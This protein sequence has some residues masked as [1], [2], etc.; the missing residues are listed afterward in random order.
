[1]PAITNWPPSRIGESAARR[2]LFRPP[3]RP[4]RRAVHHLDHVVEVRR[5][6]T[7]SMKP[8]MAPTPSTT[9]RSD[10]IHD[11][12]AG[13][14][15]CFAEALQPSQQTHPL[16][17]PEVRKISGR[18]P[19]C[20]NSAASR[21]PVRHEGSVWQLSWVDAAS[22]P[23]A[24]TARLAGPARRF[25]RRRAR[26]RR[27]RGVVR[28]TSSVPRRVRLLMA[29]GRAG[30]AVIGWRRPSV[31]DTWDK[32]D[33][34]IVDP[35]EEVRCRASATTRG[36]QLGWTGPEKPITNRRPLPPR[37]RSP[38]GRRST[39]CPQTPPLSHR[40]RTTGARATGAR[41]P[42]P[43]QDVV[44]EQHPAGPPRPDRPAPPPREPERCRPRP[45]ATA[46]HGPP[47]PRPFDTGQFSAINPQQAH[48]SRAAATSQPA[49]GG[50]PQPGRQQ[51]RRP[52]LPSPP[53]SGRLPTGRTSNAN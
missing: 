46:R 8:A 31:V 23:R 49:A 18:T 25:V 11:L 40:P 22:Q 19:R 32:A 10:D 27:R 30:L 5:L 17:P 39:S 13:I 26:G 33:S 21:P 28:G 3:A 7:R 45:P 24:R 37:H 42:A 36:E 44:F 48:H 38:H 52:R 29:A 15:Y 1:M 53:I 9:R 47:P 41:P 14:P 12:V 50:P 20:T 35:T 4:S 43:E 2:Y 51:Q 6:P 16:N 34:R